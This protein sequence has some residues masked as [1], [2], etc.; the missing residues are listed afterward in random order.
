[1]RSFHI[2]S[3][4]QVFSGMLSDAY[5]IFGCLAASYIVVVITRSN[6]RHILISKGHI[7]TATHPPSASGLW[8]ASTNEARKLPPSGYPQL[9][10]THEAGGD[11]GRG[12]ERSALLGSRDD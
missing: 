3:K 7:L 2:I 8:T 4:G 10:R 11:G 5:G 6:I 12:A 9:T 1:M